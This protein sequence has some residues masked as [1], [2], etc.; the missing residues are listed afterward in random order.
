MTEEFDIMLEDAIV[1]GDLDL[2]EDALDM[3]GEWGVGKIMEYS[4]EDYGEEFDN[5]VDKFAS[6]LIKLYDCSFQYCEDMFNILIYYLED[7]IPKLNVVTTLKEKV[8]NKLTQY[9]RLY[10]SAVG[11]IL[12]EYYNPLYNFEY[13]GNLLDNLLDQVTDENFDRVRL[14][15]PSYLYRYDPRNIKNR[16]LDIVLSKGNQ[17]DIETIL[18]T[19]VGSDLR[20]MYNNIMNK[21]YKTLNDEKLLNAIDNFTLSNKKR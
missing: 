12:D 4:V 10:G 2:F 1:S 21:P 17:T 13:K 7:K 11:R 5:L 3:L 20:T 15:A 8:N 6:I 19:Y 14:P 16:I 9:G 18:D